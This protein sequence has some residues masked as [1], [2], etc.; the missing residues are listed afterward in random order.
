MKETTKKLRLA[1]EEAK[2]KG[3]STEEIFNV[4]EETIENLET[5]KVAK[6]EMPQKNFVQENLVMEITDI[7]HEIGI[8][9]HIRGYR[10]VRDAIMFT[11][12]EPSAIDSVT[13]L[14]YPEIAKMHN[15]TASRVEKA[16]RHA[17]EVAWER[18]NPEV[19]ERYFK[20]T[21]HWNKGKPTNSE[22]IAILADRLKLKH[23][24]S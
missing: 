15:A 17:I 5:D 2:A 21:I 22:F 18:G 14:L 7:M 11:L 23:K 6:V 13:K 10:Y 24:L 12:K 16:I 19:L 9:A 3:V 20:C 4:V 8:P 1:I